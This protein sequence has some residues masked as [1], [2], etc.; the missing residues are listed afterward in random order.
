ME[1]MIKENAGC[2]CFQNYKCLWFCCS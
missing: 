2:T 1:H